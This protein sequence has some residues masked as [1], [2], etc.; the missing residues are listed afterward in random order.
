MFTPSLQGVRA[1]RW[2]V[3]LLLL[4]LCLGG[5]QGSSPATPIRDEFTGAWSDNENNQLDFIA[6]NSLLWVQKGWV[7]TEA[8]TANLLGTVARIGWEMS[9][10]Y[11]SSSI[12]FRIESLQEGASLVLATDEQPKSK[13]NFWETSRPLKLTLSSPGRSPGWSTLR[14]FLASRRE[15]QTSSP[16][17]F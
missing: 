9:D 5:C 8:T 15:A 12:V 7:R 10:Y 2:M 14:G 4:V 16:P 3:L 11:D 6:P 1:A 13:F 17:H